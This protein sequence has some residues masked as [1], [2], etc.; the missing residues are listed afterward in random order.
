MIRRSRLR[1]LLL[2]VFA[3]AAVLAMIYALYEKVSADKAWRDFVSATA[4]EVESGREAVA[5]A[6]ELVQ[7]A[8]KA[9]VDEN[10]ISTVQDQI[11]V[12]EGL[13]QELSSIPSYTEATSSDTHDAENALLDGSASRAVIDPL[14]HVSEQEEAT[15]TPS[16]PY[17]LIV[18]YS[19]VSTN[20][21]DSLDALARSLEDLQRAIGSHLDSIREALGVSREALIYEI[22]RGRALEEYAVSRHITGT[23]VEDLQ[24][25]LD[26]GQEVL[27]KQRR[28]D[29]NQAT[30]VTR[31]LV[32]VDEAV[33]SIRGTAAALVESIGV[34]AQEMLDS[35]T[36]E[37]LWEEQAY[38]VPAPATPQADAPIAPAPTPTPQ[39]PSPETPS[40][41]GGGGG[42][43]VPSP[44][45]ED[46]DG[47]TSDPGN[48][49]DNDHEQEPGDA[50]DNRGDEKHN[51]ES[52]RDF[53]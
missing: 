45:P 23:E 3:M 27:S 51:P 35:L 26:T 31:A 17:A 7:V 12:S 53:S 33:D 46:D 30:E 6:D 39:P 52:D 4:I 14:S 28:V 43:N 10:D 44:S 41:G 8:K 19:Q 5:E 16:R 2:A 32:Q 21:Q 25:A 38:W 11:A 22:V 18:E 24:A 9:G 20:L 1:A 34:D 13:L 47:P 15:A 49:G 37:Q 42:G 29:V 48:G 36:P 50:I 40:E